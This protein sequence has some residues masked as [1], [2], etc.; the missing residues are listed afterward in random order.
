MTNLQ[1]HLFFIDKID[2]TMSPIR[3]CAKKNFKLLPFIQKTTLSFK[4]DI[5]PEPKILSYTIFKNRPS[6]LYSLKFYKCN[7]RLRRLENL[8][9]VQF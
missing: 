6:N 2:T 1:I 7:I 5:K 8:T 9:S 4:S 3:Q